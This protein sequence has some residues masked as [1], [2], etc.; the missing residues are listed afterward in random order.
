MIEHRYD[1][2]QS[3]VDVLREAT[4]LARE[5]AGDTA[6]SEAFW[7]TSQHLCGTAKI[8]EVVDARCRVLGFE[9]LWVVDGSILPRIPSRGPHATIVMAGHRAAEFVS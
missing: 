7:S 3:D 6:H 2:A 8:G 5:I 1:T 4:R 9:N